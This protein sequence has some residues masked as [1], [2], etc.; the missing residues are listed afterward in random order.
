M[1]KKGQN[2]WEHFGVN[3]LSRKTLGFTECK[4]RFDLLL[5]PSPKCSQLNKTLITTTNTSNWTQVSDNP[6]FATSSSAQYIYE[7]NKLL[8]SLMERYIC[9]LASCYWAEIECTVHDAQFYKTDKRRHTLL[10]LCMK[11][12]IWNFFGQ[13]HYFE[14]FPFWSILKMATKIDIHTRPQ[15]PPNPG[16]MLEFF[17][18]KNLKKNSQKF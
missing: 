10:N 4:D 15:C 6:F 17:F 12:E 18:L 2:L 13:K 9:F 1:S 16:F 7:Y 5:S 11:F 8:A 3:G 14:G